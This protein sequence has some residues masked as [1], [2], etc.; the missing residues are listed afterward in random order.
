MADTT[1]P[2]QHPSRKRLVSNGA[3]SKPDPLT[4]TPPHPPSLFRAVSGT[5]K[6]LPS[7][8]SQCLV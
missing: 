8:P 4:A 3:R 1:L 7:Q 6:W 5:L 2:T